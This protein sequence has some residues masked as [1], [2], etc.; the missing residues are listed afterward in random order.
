MSAAS[1]RVKAGAGLGP[2]LPAPARLPRGRRN[3]RRPRNRTGG[4]ADPAFRPGTWLRKQDEACADGK[5]TEQQTALLDAL[6]GH[7]AET[8]TG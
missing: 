1:Q 6:H 7:M 8:V 4:E 5:L 3:P 2:L